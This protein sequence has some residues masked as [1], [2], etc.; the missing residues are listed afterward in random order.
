MQSNGIL[1]YLTPTIEPRWAKA[2]SS[3]AVFP[4][5]PLTASS[6]LLLRLGSLHWQ[7]PVQ[8][9]CTPNRPWCCGARLYRQSCMSTSNIWLC[10]SVVAYV[11]CSLGVPYSVP[12]HILGRRCIPICPETVTSYIG[13]SGKASNST[14]CASEFGCHSVGSG[15]RCLER[16]QW[17]RRELAETC[18]DTGQSLKG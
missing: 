15:N 11:I 5:A 14:N 16:L 13:K 4:F 10:V 1:R 3:N 17:K 9:S 8:Y 2:A 7:P 12:L 6:R 18:M